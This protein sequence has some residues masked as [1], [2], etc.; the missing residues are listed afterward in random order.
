MKPDIIATVAAI[1]VICYLIGMGCKAYGRLDK[2]IPVVVGACGAI[3]GVVG[4]YTIKE[5]PAHDVLN[6]LAV[7]IASGLASTGV[8]QVVKQLTQGNQVAIDYSDDKY[9]DDEDDTHED[10]EHENE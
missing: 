2:W 9:W 8:N 10:D 3:L 6:A 4:L 1:T 7:G 5:F